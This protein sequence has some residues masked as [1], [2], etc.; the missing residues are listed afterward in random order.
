MPASDDAL[1]I[2]DEVITTLPHHEISI[3]SLLGKAEIQAQNEDF[4]PSIE[5]LQLLIRRFPK[6]DLAVEAFLQKGHVYLM[7]CE[8]GSCDPALLDLAEVSLRKFRQAFP[9]EERIADAEKDFSNM[10]ELFAEQLMETGRFFEKTKKTS[11]AILY[12]SKVFSQYPH[13]QA[14]A[15]AQAKLDQLQLT[16]RS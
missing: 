9:R 11:A 3:R 10:E 15:V 6:H 12:Y 16:T 1:K 2:Y 8:E 4:K 14:A 5:T 13:T 7:Q